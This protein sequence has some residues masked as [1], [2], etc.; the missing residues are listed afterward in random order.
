MRHCELD[1]WVR[2]TERQLEASECTKERTTR[3]H[4]KNWN[5]T[6]RDVLLSQDGT[7]TNAFVCKS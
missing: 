7:M 1:S 3:H 5:G 6:W 2:N 4:D